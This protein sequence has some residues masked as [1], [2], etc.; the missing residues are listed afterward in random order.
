M[1]TPLRCRRS[2]RSGRNWCS[3]DPPVGDRRRPALDTEA[4]H[5]DVDIG[6][7][8]ANLAGPVTTLLTGL[9]RRDRPPDVVGCR[10]WAC[11]PA[12]ASAT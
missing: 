7:L 2:S 5:A 9:R 6:P 10:N 3:P 4:L 1:L 8:M 11:C 12:M